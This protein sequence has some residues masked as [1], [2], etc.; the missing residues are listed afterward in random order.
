LISP[1]GSALTTKDPFSALQCVM[2]II[3]F[4]MGGYNKY[5]DN[6]QYDQLTYSK[7]F[8]SKKMKELGLTFTPIRP[9]ESR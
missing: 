3:K 8:S 6:L 7:I 9:G 5:K 1:C 4:I 2:N